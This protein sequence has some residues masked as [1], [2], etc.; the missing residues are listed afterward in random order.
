MYFAEANK[1]ISPAVTEKDAEYS[2]DIIDRIL[3]KNLS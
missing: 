3:D 1:L 2:L